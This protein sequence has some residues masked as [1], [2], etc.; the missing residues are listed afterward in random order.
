MRKKLII[1]TLTIYFLLTPYSFGEKPSI[2]AQSAIL[3]DAKSGRVLLEYNPYI[4]LPMASTTKIMTALVTLEK[5]DLKDIIEVPSEAVGVEGS[6]IYLRENEKISLEDLLY[7]LMLRSGNDSAVAIAKHIGGDLEGFNRLMNKMAKK[8]GA[9]S[10]QFLNP[11]GLSEEGHYTTAY[12]LSLITKAAMENEKF[13]EISSTKKWKANREENDLFYNKNKTLWEYEGGDGVKTGYTM[14]AGRCL[15]ASATRDGT[16]LI[17]IVLNDRN[18]FEDCYK[19]M[20]YGFDNFANYVVVEE[21]KHFGE[22]PVVNG[23]KASVSVVGKKS[24]FYPLKED[25]VGKIEI[26]RELPETIN[27]PIKKG[28]R[29]GKIYVYFDGQ[30][31]HSGKLVARNNVGKL[32]IWHRLLNKIEEK[33]PIV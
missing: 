26:Y 33:S 8:I 22:I 2:S 23:N 16:Q 31:I 21:G 5:G 1:L 12:D 7:G 15:V 3:I 4:K 18:W 19:L 29:L 30:L 25:E 28:D 32:K 6:S 27:A 11:H 13:K 24:F 20:D 14:A 9:L 10:T 17:A